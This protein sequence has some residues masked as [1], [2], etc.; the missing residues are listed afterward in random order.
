MKNLID[1]VKFKLGLKKFKISSAAKERFS[2]YF[3]ELSFDKPIVQIIWARCSETNHYELLVGF[4]DKK[5]FSKI[6]AGL[7]FEIDG[8]QFLVVCPDVFQKIENKLLDYVD[9]KFVFL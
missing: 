4:N 3:V 6:Q 7:C 1:L 2:R 9:E 5:D 8:V